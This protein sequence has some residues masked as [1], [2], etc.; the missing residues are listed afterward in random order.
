MNITGMSMR[1]AA[2]GDAPPGERHDRIG[3]TRVT[4]KDREFLDVIR[5]DG[6]TTAPVMAKIKGL[7]SSAAGHRLRKLVKLGE[8]SVDSG[9]NI[10]SIGVYTIRRASPC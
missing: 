9:S 2:K 5:K 7:T 3:P 8:L 4:S 1:L 10:R 6:D